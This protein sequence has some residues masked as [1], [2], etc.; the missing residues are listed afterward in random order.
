[1]NILQEDMIHDILIDNKQKSAVRRLLDANKFVMAVFVV[2]I[3]TEIITNDFFKHPARIITAIIVYLIHFLLPIFVGKY[4]RHAAKLSLILGEMVTFNMMLLAFKYHPQEDLFWI[5][6]GALVSFFYQDFV[7]SSIKHIIFFSIK[8]VL[9]WLVAGLYFEKIP[10]SDVGAFLYSMIS[11]M[12]LYFSCAYYDYLKDIDM[13]KSRLEVQITNNKLTSIVESISDMISVISSNNDALFEN[14]AFKYY[15]KD[16]SIIDYFIECKYQRNYP[17]NQNQSNEIL[18]DIKAAFSLKIDDEINFGITQYNNELIEWRGKLIIWE[19]SLSMILFGKN[20]T[21]LLKLQKESSE[22]EYKSVLLRT[23]SHELRTPIN[24]ILAMTQMIK[25]TEL[26]KDN[27]QRINVISASCSYQLCLIN[28]L[29]D[30]AQIIAG[31]LKISVASFNI[32]HLLS[33]CINLIEV[34]LKDSQ[35]TFSLKVSELPENLISDPH[36]IKQILLNLL[37]N[38]KKFTLIGSITLDVIYSNGYLNIR[39]I[40]T[41]I[42]ISSEKLSILFTQFGRI[43]ESSSINPQGVGLGLLISNML[44]KELGGDG[45]KVESEVNQG[46]C[47]SFNLKADEGKEILDIADENTQIYIPSIFTKSLTENFKILIVD[48]TYFNILAY[49]EIFKSEGI[50]C[51]YSLNGEDALKKL[52]E[53]YFSCVLMDCEMPIIDGWETTKRIKEMKIKKEIWYSPV[54]IACTANNLESIQQKCLDAGMDDII[55]KPCAKELLIAK[56]KHWINTIK[57]IPREN[58]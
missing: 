18:Q 13:C 14:A 3:I 49:T 12:M 50:I 33:E 56:V 9:I 39:C 22:N 31:C 10:L 48:D 27:I 11:L 55:I 40:D 7:L 44:V 16:K 37:S 51:E 32:L 54:V 17:E 26:T 19:N 5:Q 43:S 15:V 28:D 36:R 21:N 47:F 53:K 1:M 57:I 8:Q 46:T 35:V 42:G 24:A 41:G 25:T 30:Y 20:V 6:A 29:L 4:E 23:V 52:K 45:I 34:Q 38:A 2:R 58:H